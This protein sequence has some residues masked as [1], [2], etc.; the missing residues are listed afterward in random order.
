LDFA[1]HGHAAQ[2]FWGFY[3]TVTVLHAIHLSVGIGAVGRLL[4]L[5]R[6]G[7]IRAQ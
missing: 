1:F 5:D 7:E 6:R 3:W 4:L 2:L